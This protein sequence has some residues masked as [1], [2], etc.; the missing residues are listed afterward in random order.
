MITS[1]NF[2]LHACLVVSITD[3]VI[4]GYSLQR[5]ICYNVTAK[6]FKS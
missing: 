5:I 4:L 1:V 3:I 6:K 2:I